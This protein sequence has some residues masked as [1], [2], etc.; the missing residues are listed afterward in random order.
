VLSI[1]EDTYQGRRG[2]A[3]TLHV[4]IKLLEQL[5]RLTGTGNS[6]SGRKVGKSAGERRSLTINE[7]R[8]IEGLMEHLLLRALVVEVGGHI[9]SELTV[10]EYSLDTDSF[11]ISVNQTVTARIQFL[12]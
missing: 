7:I 2:V 9:N 4:S 8:W 6:A 3:A 10:A 11:R 5:G 12:A 1:L